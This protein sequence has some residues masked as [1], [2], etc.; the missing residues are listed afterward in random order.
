MY[1]R[2]DVADHLAAQTIPDD[3]L[4]QMP[5][6]SIWAGNT[7]QHQIY[8]Q[9]SG[10]DDYFDVPTLDGIERC[11]N[12]QTLSLQLLPPNSPADVSALALLPKLQSID[13]DGGT[14]STLQP[15]L[16]AATL[17]SI[18]FTATDIAD[19]SGNQGV[20]DQLRSR[21]CQLSFRAMRGLS[22]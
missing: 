7:L 22:G 8:P 1:K 16:D 9:W 17:S 2:Q 15:L 21:G 14:L 4:R 18:S 20:I 3:T 10:E 13:F 5:E 11:A 12:L 19:T 6:L